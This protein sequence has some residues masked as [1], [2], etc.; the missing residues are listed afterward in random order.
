MP[1]ACIGGGA[2][3]TLCGRKKVVGCFLP[4]MVLVNNG[5]ITDL[6]DDFLYVSL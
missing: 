3:D 1:V 4:S 2:K 6:Q 5:M